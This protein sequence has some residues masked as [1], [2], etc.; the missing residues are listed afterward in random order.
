MDG[1]RRSDEEDGQQD[2][3]YLCPICNTRVNS[4][5]SE[6]PGCGA[7]FVDDEE[8][9]TPPGDTPAEALTT[10]GTDTPLEYRCPAC[11]GTV[12]EEDE[13]CPHCGALFV[14]EGEQDASAQPPEPEIEPEPEPEPF[15]EAPP[16]RV[17]AKP[18]LKV[19]QKPEGEPE[20]PKA[21]GGLTGMRVPSLSTPKKPAP[22]GSRM[23]DRQRYRH[24][25]AVKRLA[26]RRR[27][28]AKRRMLGLALLFTGFLI[29]VG[30]FMITPEGLTIGSAF[31]LI[32]AAGLILTGML[33]IFNQHQ[34]EKHYQ[35][36]LQTARVEAALLRD[37]VKGT[38][39]APEPEP[40]PEPEPAPP[41]RLAIQ[42]ERVVVEPEVKV[43]P[44]KKVVTGAA[45]AADPDV[46]PP[47]DIKEPKRI[48]LDLDEPIEQDKVPCPNCGYMNRSIFVRCIRCGTELALRDESISVETFDRPEEPDDSEEL[49]PRGGPVPWEARKASSQGGRASA[50]QAARAAARESGEDEE[51]EDR[52]AAIGVAANFAKLPKNMREELIRTLYKVSDP[53][54]RQDTVSA[55]AEHYTEL[56]KDIQDL[57]LDLAEDED[58]RVREEVAFEVNRNFDRIPMGII[59]SIFAKLAR[60][61]ENLVRE[62][63][64]SAIAE[65]FQRLP[66]ETQDLLKLL[67]DDEKES[68]RD[69]VSFEVAKNSDVIPEKFKSEVK[70]ILRQA[71][72]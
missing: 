49:R 48:E 63:V 65:N 68:V 35:V 15:Q 18:K 72:S 4:T 56:P 54:V 24:S 53:V 64:V 5:Q 50:R 17:R 19:K 59:Q 31:I 39:P 14:E 9:A 47:I 37:K 61:P 16:A 6:C 52:R 28:I 42:P 40:E 33:I 67:A 8:G 32:A 10:E 23:R 55:I 27:L 71:G 13:T 60:D 21:R 20:P 7:I 30:S 25:L 3:V 57:L 45:A 66:K 51:T 43:T 29:Y 12:S 46:E 34:A 69:E 36:Q 22:A 1:G 2:E 70:E 38:K 62:D 41:K 26:A 58:P 11:G 44:K